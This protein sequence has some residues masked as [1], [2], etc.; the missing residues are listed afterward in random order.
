MK[1]KTFA[2]E[3]AEFG[4]Q[5]WYYKPGITGK[6]KL[7]VRWESGIW[8]GIR[9]ESGE[10]IVGTSKGVLKDRSLRKNLSVND[11]TVMHCK[12]CKDCHGSQYLDLG[13]ERSNR[14]CT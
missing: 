10:V 7:D 6:D 11:G 3:V 9:D 13:N 14:Q 5:V 4:E 2:R 12:K 8:L 1:G